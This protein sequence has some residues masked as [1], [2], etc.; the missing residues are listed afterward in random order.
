MSALQ[1]ANLYLLKAAESVKVNPSAGG[2]PGD[3][4]VQKL[5]NGGARFALLACVGVVIVGA[6]QWGFGKNTSNSSH[7]DDGKS[8]MLKGAGGAFAIGAAAAVVNF[9]FGAG[10]GVH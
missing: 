5:I 9:F 1:T 4:A 3:E 8:R 2:L 7:A 10:S 6:A